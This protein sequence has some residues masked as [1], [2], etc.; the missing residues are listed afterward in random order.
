MEILSIVVLIVV[1]V[2]LWKFRKVTSNTV[3]IAENRANYM[4]R[5]QELSLGEDWAKLQSKLVDMDI[6]SEKNYKEA[7][8][9]KLNTSAPKKS[10]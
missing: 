4:V 1:V 3:A 2:A 8:K 10:K 9:A 5:S 6:S 7:L